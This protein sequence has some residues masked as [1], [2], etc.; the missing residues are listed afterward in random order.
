MAW[1]F[2]T[3]AAAA[4]VIFVL[5]GLPET[6]SDEHFAGKQDVNALILTALMQITLA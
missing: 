2:L 4:T 3:T 6:F 1:S 5:S